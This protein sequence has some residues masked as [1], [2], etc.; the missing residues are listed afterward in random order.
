MRNVKQMFICDKLVFERL[1]M[2][3]S[4]TQITHFLVSYLWYTPCK[5]YL[6]RLL[7]AD[8]ENG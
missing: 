6:P 1:N 5:N 4:F 8:K 3:I 2:L 7:L